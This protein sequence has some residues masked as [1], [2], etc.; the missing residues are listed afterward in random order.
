MLL[1]VWSKDNSIKD[2]VVEAY[3]RLYLNPSV[4]GQRYSNEEFRI[5]PRVT[6][7][8]IQ[9]NELSPRR[10]SNPQPSDLR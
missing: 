2:A 6:F 10:E 1:L 9:K 4:E 7:E 8:Q 3:E 5:I